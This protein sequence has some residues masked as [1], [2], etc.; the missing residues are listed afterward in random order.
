MIADP[1]QKPAMDVYRE[2]FNT[3]HECMLNQFLGAPGPNMVDFSG[4]LTALEDAA[5]LEIIN[6]SRPLDDFDQF[7]A[8]WK[9]SGGDEVT[10]EAN[11]WYASV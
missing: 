2:V 11:E 3:Q 4:H 8:D 1:G 9:K 6:G 5:Y 7:V 10:A